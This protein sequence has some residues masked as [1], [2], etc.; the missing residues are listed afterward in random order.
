MATHQEGVADYYNRNTRRFLRL[1]RGGAQLAI[2]RPVWAPGVRGTRQA[3][4]YINRRIEEHIAD[5]NA[6][7]ILDLGCGVGGSM[8]DL[9][10]SWD[11]RFA[12]VTI[13][14][15]QKQIGDEIILKRGFQN[16]IRIFE[17]DF[18]DPGVFR[19]FR[20]QQIIYAVESLVHLPEKSDITG[21]IADSLAPGGR[22][23]ICDDMLTRAEEVLAEREKSVLADFRRCWHAPGI[24]SAA[25]W[26]NAFTKAGLES[27]SAEDFTPWLKLF[28]PRD[29][30][31]A[32]IAPFLRSSRSPWTENIV[33]GTALQ[34][35]LSRGITQ[36]RF[37]VFRKP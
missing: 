24:R 31:A 23:I 3:A 28:R 12:G 1:G 36:Y 26:I 16:R 10:A 8:I 37:L 25:G 11:G 30:A 5:V 17:G 21:F 13:S 2:H 15:E 27:L 19:L 34:Y 32:A 18:S 33:G 14:H 35:M 22:F 20:N 6:Q 4:L 7:E 29:I 9:A